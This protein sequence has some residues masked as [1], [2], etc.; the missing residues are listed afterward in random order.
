MGLEL[1]LMRHGEAEDADRAG[2]D[3]ERGLTERG[4][5]QCAA[6]GQWLAERTGP[7]QLILHSPLKRAR[8]TAEAFSH[9]T[10]LQAE[11]EL[12]P[13]MRA[14]RL[15]N[16]LNELGL[17]RVACVGHQPDIGQCLVDCIGSSRVQIPP[18]TLAVVTFSSATAVIGGGA[19]RGLLD[20]AWFSDR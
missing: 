20:P 16:A 1:W 6:V 18:G 9:G 19:L 13:G 14:D 7:P 15:L 8:E 2:S 3:A 4:R 12:G 11:P 10:P 17:S 5:R